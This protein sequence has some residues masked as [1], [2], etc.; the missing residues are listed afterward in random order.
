MLLCT[1]APTSAAAKSSTFSSSSG[2]Q[3]H[4]LRVLLLLLLAHVPVA[5]RSPS[6]TLV[7]ILRLS[8]V[9]CCNFL[10][11]NTQMYAPL[12][13]ACRAGGRMGLRWVG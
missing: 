13:Q 8:A 5:G 3:A 10:I 11:D 7:H 6:C 2:L 1:H 12:T 9:S 4:T